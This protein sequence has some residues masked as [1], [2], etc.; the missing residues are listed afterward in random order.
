MQKKKK[1][2][3]PQTIILA[4]FTE[5]FIAEKELSIFAGLLASLSLFYAT[6]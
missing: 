1:D 3:A 4:S 2:H 5:G 6:R